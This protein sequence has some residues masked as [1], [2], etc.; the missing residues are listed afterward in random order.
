MHVEPPS[1]HQPSAASSATPSSLAENLLPACLSDKSIL[2]RAVSVADIPDDAGT[3]VNRLN[4]K[5]AELT[6]IEAGSEGHQSTREMRACLSEIELRKSDYIE[7]EDKFDNLA[8][9]LTVLANHKDFKSLESL[10]AKNGIC[11]GLGLS[12]IQSIIT[13]TQNEFAESLRLLSRSSQEGWLYDGTLYDSLWE[14]IQ[15]ALKDYKN[16][17]ALKG[18]QP[19]PEGKSLFFDLFAQDHPESFKYIQIMARLDS[20]QLYQVPQNTF[21]SHSITE[22]D[23]I[24]ASAILTPWFLKDTPAEQ[25]SFRAT[26]RWIA[27]VTPEGLEDILSTLPSGAYLLFI[28]GHSLSIDVADETVTVFDQNIPLYFLQAKRSEQPSLTLLAKKLHISLSVSIYDT[29]NS[30][31]V[32]LGI[33]R[34]DKQSVDLQE[35]N[36]TLKEIM[37]RNG[38]N[39][40]TRP[41]GHKERQ[42]LKLAVY[43][44]NPDSV[45]SLVPSHPSQQQG[46]Q[47]QP[48]L[49]TALKN[50]AGVGVIKALLDAGATLDTSFRSDQILITAAIK[51]NNPETLRWL[52]AG[53]FKFLPT[54]IPKDNSLLKQAL[55][56]NC[57]AAARTL[58]QSGL[59]ARHGSP[60][61]DE[62][63]H[64]AILKRAPDIIDTLLSKYD[65]PYSRFGFLQ[66]AITNPDGD[67]HG[68][69]LA[70]LL[71][72]VPE[73]TLNS[74]DCSGKSPL[75]EAINAHNFNAIEKLFE[76]GASV[77]PE[78]ESPLTAAVETGQT[79]IV[80]LLLEKGASPDIKHIR[81]AIA[82]GDI[83]MFNSLS[84]IMDSQRL[85]SSQ[86]LMDSARYQRIDILKKLID[87][88]GSDPI[89]SENGRKAFN[90]AVDYGYSEI[91][92][93]FL[94]S[95][96]KVD[97]HD[98]L[99]DSILH[100]AVK[101]GHIET[102]RTI[103]ECCAPANEIPEFKRANEKQLT[104]LDIALQHQ[105]EERYK[106]II[107]LLESEG[108]RPSETARKKS[109][110]AL[111]QRNRLRSTKSGRRP[112]GFFG[113]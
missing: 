107:S 102:V 6:G 83:E 66:E 39:I 38:E 42:A 98:Y 69:M 76:R 92:R 113:F 30:V 19:V 34:F 43:A 73:E 96:F 46:D 61:L 74:K 14:P 9:N 31:P 20:L 89:N 101:S 25:P 87:K 53:K 48:L 110:A 85:D 65:W 35:P 77:T 7:Y 50:G 93:L 8:N 60:P 52:S 68:E 72:H 29:D 82:V 41:F 97:W 47:E 81:A 104:P 88:V 55:D 62:L 24:K 40:T 78:G 22:Q 16:Y 99:G 64:T 94:A 80:K 111:S 28:E 12:H 100:R 2:D 4:Q 11:Y 86:L 18:T 44:N 26:Q 63:I 106:E 5:K 71:K 51:G 84:N 90:L 57:M 70:V 67:L 108:F 15:L 109:R 13:G 54:R 17:S 23:G 27:M 32:P 36:E 79:H 10:D 75:Y 91:V 95:D 3:V 112:S 49:I 1:Q 21:M 103:L 59:P 37:V 105:S 45:R 58:I 33:Q 56:S